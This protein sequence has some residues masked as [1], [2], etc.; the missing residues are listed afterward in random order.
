MITPAI[1]GID[2][3]T[4][5]LDVAI[6]RGRA[7][8][9]L[10]SW[11]L[12]S[13]LRAQVAV[14]SR[15]LQELRDQ[16]VTE[17]VMEQPWLR[18]GRGIGSA[19]ELHKTPTRVEALAALLGIDTLFV[20]INRWHAVVLGNGGLKS[21]AGKRASLRYVELVY[22]QAAA[23]HNQSDAICLATYGEAVRKRAPA[24]VR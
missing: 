1:A 5:A 22:G 14:I 8:A 13:E 11:D 19:M 9:Y 20:A 12:G 18:E 15:A 2:Y 3:S 6:V 7:V 10:K 17:I 21:A 23:S 4:K 16:G 24:A